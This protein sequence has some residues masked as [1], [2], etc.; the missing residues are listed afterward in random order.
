[1]WHNNIRNTESTLELSVE[2]PLE[3]IHKPELCFTTL[4]VQH[5]LIS[6][7]LPWITLESS[8]ELQTESLQNPLLWIPLIYWII[9][10]INISEANWGKLSSELH[11]IQSLDCLRHLI[12]MVVAY[13]MKSPF[14]TKYKQYIRLRNNNWYEY[15]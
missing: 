8:S 14:K 5:L 4:V 1:M 11:L 7:L 15:C 9:I 10:N 6:L 3:A 2:P 12:T 13:L